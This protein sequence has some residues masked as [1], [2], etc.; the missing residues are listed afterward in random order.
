[1]RAGTRPAAGS[2]SSRTIR[3]RRSPHISRS[4]ASSRET[5]AGADA[6]LAD[7]ARTGRSLPFPQG[8]FSAAYNH[9]YASWIHLQLGELDRA[10]EIME[11]TAALAEAH[12]FDFWSIA[13]AIQRVAIA[14]FRNLAG[15][16]VDT[17]AL[18]GQAAE[19]SGLAMVWQMVDARLF[20][21]PV[22][23]HGRH[24]ARGDRGC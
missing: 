19:L 6:A 16:P 4:L 20:L 21:T 24:D 10:T 23:D 9:S 11:S 14:I 17:A 12:G 1:M 3:S 8:P 13:A 22:A 15:D 7:A 5:L 2:G 18:S